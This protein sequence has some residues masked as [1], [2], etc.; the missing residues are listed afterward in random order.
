MNVIASLAIEF[1]LVGCAL[2]LLNTV[3][4][5]RPL[6]GRRLAAIILLG[7]AAFIVAVHTTGA[8]S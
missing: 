5:G 7:L 2:V 8:P 3:P 4:F 1:S 6:G